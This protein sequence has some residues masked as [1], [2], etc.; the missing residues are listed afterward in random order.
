MAEGVVK[1]FNYTF[2]HGG[3]LLSKNFPRSILKVATMTNRSFLIE[4]NRPVNFQQAFTDYFFTITLIS[5]KSSF[6]CIL[7]WVFGRMHQNIVNS[8]KIRRHYAFCH[9]PIA[10]LPIKTPDPA[11]DNGSLRTL[12]P[13][14]ANR[15]VC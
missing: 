14:A 11:S 6:V 1:P 8:P 5:K 4:R 10:C 9:N 7:S 13:H 3:T 2:C 15:M 12:R